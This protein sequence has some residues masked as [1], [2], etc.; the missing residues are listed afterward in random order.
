M[1]SDTGCHRFKQ[2]DI[3]TLRLTASKKFD[4]NK[5]THWQ[6]ELQVPA[7]ELEEALKSR[8]YL[9]IWDGG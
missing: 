9:K 1:V 8:T 5:P 4:F 2:D 7:Q 6:V 3:L